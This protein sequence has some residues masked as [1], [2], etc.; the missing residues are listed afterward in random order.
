MLLLKAGTGKPAESSFSNLDVA[1]CRI[2]GSPLTEYRKLCERYGEEKAYRIEKRY[3]GNY[4][5]LALINTGNHNLET[6]RRYA[7]TVADFFNLTLEE[8]PGSFRLL[9]KLL[10]GD[11]DDEF[12]VV[13][14]GGT[15]HP[16]L[17]LGASQKPAC[18]TVEENQAIFQP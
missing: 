3:I 1:T 4:T 12:V 14:P 13:E 6:Y 18:L 5:R 8:I 7:A 10:A 2:P 15:V 16:E 9:N 11:W 17:F